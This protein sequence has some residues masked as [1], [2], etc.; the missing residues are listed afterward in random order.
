MLYDTYM[1]VKA[2]AISHVLIFKP[3]WNFCKYYTAEESNWGL[4]NLK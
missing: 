4:E 3:Y 1:D 2:I